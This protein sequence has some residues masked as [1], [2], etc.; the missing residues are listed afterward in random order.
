[1]VPEGA[2][3]DDAV[4]DV[5]PPV[6]IVVLDV[7]LDDT[8]LLEVTAVLPVGA[9]ASGVPLPLSP[10]ADV[11]MD[12]ASAVSKVEPLTTECKTRERMALT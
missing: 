1:V 9:T 7:V 6:E 3:F 10:Q 12:A 2:V 4:F 8:A 11:R 5:V